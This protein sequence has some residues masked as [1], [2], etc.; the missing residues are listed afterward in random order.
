MVI[1]TSDEQTFGLEKQCDCE[2]NETKGGTVLDPFGG[3]GT[4]GVV[5]SKHN[6]NAVLCELNE[7][8]I[9]IAEKR[10]NDGFDIFSSDGLEII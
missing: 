7:G 2:T 1:Q 10:L 5:A 8:Y 6:R 3:S 9:D 4:T